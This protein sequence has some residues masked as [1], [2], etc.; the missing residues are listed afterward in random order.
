MKKPKQGN[1]TGA[2]THGP[3]TPESMAG[4]MPRKMAPVQMR[5]HVPP[6]AGVG[7]GAL[8]GGKSRNGGRTG[9]L[10]NKE[11]QKDFRSGEN[12]P[13]SA[14][15]VRVGGKPKPGPARKKPGPARKKRYEL[16]K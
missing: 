6:S 12:A 9:T 7:K 1:K 14:R 8:L 5:R 16:R 10:R 13:A 2:A 11:Q 4:M 15:K 3:M